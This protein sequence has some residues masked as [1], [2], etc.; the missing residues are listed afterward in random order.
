MHKKI[1]MQDLPLGAVSEEFKQ[2]DVVLAQLDLHGLSLLASLLANGL[3]VFLVRIFFSI[4]V[5]FF[6]IVP[7]ACMVWCTGCGL[8]RLVHSNY[9]RSGHGSYSRRW[10]RSSAHD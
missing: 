9:W 7:W 2:I 5:L 8:F 6:V 1:I 10:L 3:V 4:R